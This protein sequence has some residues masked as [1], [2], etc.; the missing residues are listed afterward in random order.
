MSLITGTTSTSA[1]LR[2]ATAKLFFDRVLS[3]KNGHRLTRI[4]ID[5]GKFIF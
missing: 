1:V 4:Y 2:H 3:R 5:K